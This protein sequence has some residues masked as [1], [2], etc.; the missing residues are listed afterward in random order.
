[1]ENLEN[2]ENGQA[3]PM[4]APQGAYTDM[5][6]ADAGF[7]TATVNQAGNYQNTAPNYQAGNYQNTAPDYQA[8]NY[9]TAA[10]AYEYQAAAAAAVNQVQ[11][12]KHENVVAGIVGAFLFAL[13]GGGLHFIIY[14]FGYIAGICGLITVVLSTF[15]YQLF[16]GVKGSV[17]G[18]VIAVIMSLLAI[19]LGEFLGLSYV[20]YNEFKFTYDITF[21]DAVRATPDFLAESSELMAS[22]IK[23][24]VIAFALG[25]LASASNIHSAIKGAKGNRKR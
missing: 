17:K 6:G 14:Q 8:G 25:A 3:E 11:E 12:K 4:S 20:I 23:D 2:Y 13:I 19:V 18:I 10:S 7:Q 21:F 9:Q 16:S 24:L 5:P 15:G 22:F 1:M